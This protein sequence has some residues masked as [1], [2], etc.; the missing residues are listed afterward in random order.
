MSR[1]RRKT[2]SGAMLE[3][4]RPPQ[5]AGDPIGCLATTYT[6]NPA[7]FEEQCLARFMDIESDPTR[8]DLAYVIERESRLGGIYAGV[9][10]DHTQAGVAHSLRWDVLPV[11]IRGGKQH[12][13]VSLLVWNRH[14]RV[15]V[16]SANLTE[17]G[18]RYN[19]EVAGTVDFRPVESDAEM[20]GDVIRFLRS[21]ISVAPGGMEDDKPR[22]VERAIAFL[23]RTESL[24]NEWLPLGRRG[25]VRQHFICTMPKVGGQGERS[26]LTEAIGACIR[27]GLAPHTVRIASPFFDV[28]DEGAVVVSTLIK[29]MGRGLTRDLHLCVPAATADES[30]GVTRL[31]A[32]KAIFDRP[33]QYGVRVEVGILPAKDGDKN[34]RA[35]HAKMLL[36]AA[37][38]YTALMVGSSNFTCAGMGVGRNRNAEANLIT[39]VDRVDYGREAGSLESVWPDC[40]EVEDPPSAEWLGSGSDPEEGSSLAMLPVPEGFVSATYRAGKE[41]K[42]VLSVVPTSL[43]MNWQVSAFAD[44][45]RILLSA[46]EWN[47]NGAPSLIEMP[48]EGDAVPDRL[49]IEWEGHEACLPINVDD[50]SKLPPP[51]QLS[52]MSAEDLLRIWASADPGAA[53]RVWARQQHQS[54]LFDSDL[55]AVTPTE[56]DPLR[57]Y[58]LATTFLHRVRHRARVL[59]QLRANLQRPVSSHQALEWRL[60]GLVGIELLADRMLKEFLLSGENAG[61]ALLSLADFLIVLSEVEYQPSEGALSK[62]E[63]GRIFLPFLRGLAT[64]LNT[65]SQERRCQVSSDLNEFWE[66]V[67]QQCLR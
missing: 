54:D 55:D 61:E 40:A 36:L 25:T 60:R 33:T 62:A 14:V 32:P 2:N 9:L 31:A 34:E 58:N 21:L 18:Y 19:Q 29:S 38:G 66:R 46:K 51:S 64:R 16:A 42:I 50:S 28:N 39:L 27:R 57:M 48:W 4:W 26:A 1:S 35:W 5:G 44:V 37:D 12:A 30:G 11:R 7:V 67:I 59:A 24:T 41:N 63:F 13:K 23:D 15:I 56:L 17:P 65:Q 43:P 22:A 45:R 6:F 53:F 47:A 3:L 20:L 10:A 52:S 8:E 49:M